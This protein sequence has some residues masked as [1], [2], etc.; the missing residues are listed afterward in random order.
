MADELQNLAADL[1]RV[2]AEIPQT[3]GL[4]DDNGSL[5]AIALQRTPGA[6]NGI[7]GRQQAPS[8]AVP[9]PF[10]LRPDDLNPV[11]SDP[12]QTVPPPQAVSP[13]ISAPDPQ[14]IASSDL[15]PEDL[16]G[17]T[18]DLLDDQ[19]VPIDIR[20]DDLLV[21]TSPSQAPVDFLNVQPQTPQDQE[22]VSKLNTRIATSYSEILA[23]ETP[24]FAELSRTQQTDLLNR[25]RSQV[26]LEA[27]LDIGAEQT[28][29]EFVSEDLLGDGGIT[30]RLPFIGA[31][32]DGVYF[33]QAYSAAKAI[34]S[35]SA[36]LADWE[37]LADFQE[38]IVSQ[39]RGKTIPAQAAS[40]MSESIPFM[41]EF[42]AS[43]GL[44]SLVKGGARTLTKEGA[45]E[46]AKKSL[47]EILLVGAR[48]TVTSAGETLIRLPV[49]SHRVAADAIR[50]MI[51]NFILQPGDENDI[52][53]IVDSPGDELM[54]AL[55]N[56]TLDTSIEIFSEQSGQVLG[57]LGL[58]AGKVPGARMTL[59][60]FNDFKATVVAG[61]M[62][63]TGFDLRRATEFLARAGYHGVIAEMGEERVG[64]L[65][66]AAV[67]L[68]PLQFPSGEQ[69]AAE[70]LAFAGIGA[71]GTASASLFQEAFPKTRD[72]GDRDVEIE[73]AEK[74][75]K[76][77]Q[78]TAPTQPSA[79]TPQTPQ[80]GGSSGEVGRDESPLDREVDPTGAR[81]VLQQGPEGR[82]RVFDTKTQKVQ[83]RFGENVPP[84]TAQTIVDELNEIEQ[85]GSIQPAPQTPPDPDEGLNEITPEIASDLVEIKANPELV[86]ESLIL[87][88]FEH[89]KGERFDYFLH[90]SKQWRYRVQARNIRREIKNPR[91]GGWKLVPQ[92]NVPITVKDF[93]DRLRLRFAEIQQPG[94]QSKQVE[95]RPAAESDQEVKEL[96]VQINGLEARLRIGQN[97]FGQPLKPAGRKQIDQLL[98]SARKRLLALREPP[99]A[100]EATKVTPEPVK[101][102][103]APETAPAAKP[104]QEDQLLD[105]LADR[106]LPEPSGTAAADFEERAEQLEKEGKSD[107]EIKEI[108]DREFPPAR[109]ASDIVEDLEKRG[110]PTGYIALMTRPQS[111]LANPQVHEIARSR[112]PEVPETLTVFGAV[113]LNERGIWDDLIESAL[114]GGVIPTA[115]DQPAAPTNLTNPATPIP[116]SIRATVYRATGSKVSPLAEGVPENVFGVGTYYAF[117]KAD[118][119]LFGPDVNQV[120]VDL[121]NPYWITNHDDYTNMLGRAFP[122]T[123]EEYQGIAKLARAFMAKHGHDGVVVA[124]PKQSDIDF[125][126]KNAKRLRT[127]FVV[128]Q[129]FKIEEARQQQ[130]PEIPVSGTPPKTSSET[131]S[132]IAEKVASANPAK[133]AKIRADA[134]KMDKSIDEKMNPAIATQ[135]VTRRRS[136]I[137]E[138][139][140]ADG[141]RLIKIQAQ[142]RAIADRLDAG[143][144]P[145]ELATVSGRAMLERLNFVRDSANL[146]FLDLKDMNNLVKFSKTGKG[147]RDSKV[148]KARDLVSKLRD[149][150]QVDDIRNTFGVWVTTS[151]ESAAVN[152]LLK[153]LKDNDNR[154]KVFFQL[155]DNIR[156]GLRFIRAYES[157]NDPAGSRGLIDKF[158]VKMK[159]QLDALETK[160]VGERTDEQKELEKAERDLIGVQIPGFFPTPEPVINTLL[161]KAEIEADHRVLEPS[162]GKGDIAEKLREIV[163]ADNLAINELSLTLRDILRKKGFEG[164]EGD[165]FDRKVEEKYDRIVMNPPFEKGADIDHVSRAFDM[166]KPGGRLVSIMGEGV[167]SR[168][169]KKEKAFREFLELH[170][171]EIEKLPEGAF[172]SSF[173]ST[174]VATRVVTIDKESQGDLDKIDQEVNEITDKVVQL[175]SRR[176]IIADSPPSPAKDENLKRLDEQ[177]EAERGKV[178]GKIDEEK[179]VRDQLE[180]AVAAPPSITSTAT[181]S[182]DKSATDI[183]NENADQ[184]ARERTESMVQQIGDT[185]DNGNETE[186]PPQTQAETVPQDAQDVER[187]KEANRQ[188]DHLDGG[189]DERRAVRFQL[190]DDQRQELDKQA[191]APLPD[192]LQ[193]LL[194][195]KQI[196][197]DTAARLL[198]SPPAL[199][200]VTYN[201]DFFKPKRVK[202]LTPLPLGV[203]TEA[204]A[205]VDRQK[206][207]AFS[208]HPF[209]N[210]LLPKWVELRRKI[211]A[212]YHAG[213]TEVPV[214]GV[215]NASFWAE[216]GAESKMKTLAN[217]A[218]KIKTTG[219]FKGT[220]PFTAKKQSLPLGR[221][222]SGSMTDKIKSMQPGMAR[223][224]TR[225]AINKIMITPTEAVVTDNRVMWKME[226]DFTD[227]LGGKPAA[228]YTLDKKGKPTFD[229]EQEGKTLDNGSR[230]F[231]PE[232]EDQ[233]HFPAWKDVMPDHVDPVTI[234]IESTYDA[235]R[236]SKVMVHEEAK[237]VIIVLNPPTESKPQ[238]ERSLG[239]VT[240]NPELGQSEINV[241][242]DAVVI[243]AINPDFMMQALKMH[244]KNGS[245]TVEFSMRDHDR[246]VRMDGINATTIVMPVQ[247]GSGAFDAARRAAAPGLY[248]SDVE[249]TLS[250]FRSDY[251]TT[252]AV[253]TGLRTA[254]RHTETGEIWFAIEGSVSY[255]FGV[256]PDKYVKGKDENQRADLAIESGFVDPSGP[257][258]VW[259]DR[260]EVIHRIARHKELD[261]LMHDSG[262]A[263]AQFNPD[264]VKHREALATAID[265]Y[266]N[267]QGMLNVSGAGSVGKSKMV[268]ERQKMVDAAKK[269]SKAL[270][271]LSE[272][273]DQDFILGRSGSKSIKRIT[274]AKQLRYKLAQREINKIDPDGS[275]VDPDISSHPVQE[276]TAEELEHMRNNPDKPTFGMGAMANIPDT[277]GWT[278]KIYDN[279]ARRM[280]NPP[281]GTVRERLFKYIGRGIYGYQWGMTRKQFEEFERIKGARNFADAVASDIKAI[282]RQD[283]EERIKTREKARGP[284]SFVRREVILKRWRRELEDALRGDASITTLSKRQLEIRELY[285]APTRYVTAQILSNEW[286][287]PYLRAFGLK[288]IEQVIAIRS[289]GKGE[290]LRRLYEAKPGDLMYPLKSTLREVNIGFRI[291]GGQF[292]LRRGDE[293]FYY[294]F[295]TT[296]P[297]NPQ[298]FAFTNEDD[299]ETERLRI[300][301]LKIGELGT[302]VFD[303]V[304]I[305]DPFS[306]DELEAKGLIKPI[307]DVEILMTRSLVD[308]LENLQT[309]KTFAYLNDTVGIESAE[310]VEGYIDLPN[311]PAL[312]PLAGRAVPEPIWQAL[313]Q[314]ETV[315]TG[316]LFRVWHTYNFA[317]KKSKVL[318]SLPTWMRNLRSVV[319]FQFLDNMNPITDAKWLYQA[320]KEFQNHGPNWE[321]LVKRNEI[322]RGWTGAELKDFQTLVTDNIADWPTSANE[323]ID[324]HPKLIQAVKKWGAKAKRVEDLM[325]NLYEMPDQ[326]VKLASYLKKTQKTG[327]TEDE[328]VR[329]LWMYHNYDRAGRFAVR[330]RRSPI[331]PLFIMFDEQMLKIYMRAFRDKPGR[332]LALATA[333]ALITLATRMLLGVSD[334]EMEILNQDVRRQGAWVN[335]YMQPIIPIRDDTG[336]IQFIDLRYEFPMVDLFKLE[337]GAGG[338]ALPYLLTQ[339]WIQMIKEAGFNQI[340]YTG[341]AI[342]F[343]GDAFMTKIGKFAQHA[344]L[345][346]APIPSFV[347]KRGGGGVQRIFNAALGNGREG[348]TRVLLREVFGIRVQQPW[349]RRE[350]AFKLC[351]QLYGQDAADHLLTTLG[352]FDEIYAEEFDRRINVSD[353]ARAHRRDRKRELEIAIARGGEI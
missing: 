76:K 133:A 122:T 9:T 71:G 46:I 251:T 275:I 181:P 22:R 30:R 45:E 220:T 297:K 19:N 177:I 280:L 54:A 146:A 128:S 261:E 137:I 102:V 74:G 124:V 166:L 121:L 73:A 183:E 156:D 174:G 117:T 5:Q 151:E 240:Y 268:I 253:D 317:F 233:I 217:K 219:V 77:T 95:A 103:V 223:E 140:R 107:D 300:I 229:S 323:W 96:E 324:G 118:A 175:R 274:A 143:T 17:F 257:Q 188:T 291:R 86:K 341:Q 230:S 72:L 82:I 6:N 304:V 311:H 246:P 99:K 37:I 31:V 147:A 187:I 201:L 152:T 134:D 320:I 168:Q 106:D 313:N 3:P 193:K 94:I 334:D 221:E 155:G 43:G 61:F 339:P 345:T 33:Y 64:E 328:A 189:V 207:I 267:Y 108:L 344:V 351:K 144:L 62:Q 109:S 347:V 35:G 197:F 195:Q 123:V 225:Y 245:E 266:D 299:A 335:K 278:A 91:T 203:P 284:I 38:D 49:F 11:L 120:E 321:V 89:T 184:A 141:E 97:I 296:D 301:D 196:P 307:R 101:P 138:G 110:V 67:G 277:R 248:A 239:F 126:G 333:P 205:E 34:E 212:A 234:D 287:W 105:D 84:E 252:D 191:A 186:A 41:V 312:G 139:M 20:P 51:P 26:G 235:L 44:V 163:G 88:G 53:F 176:D 244:W 47:S 1:A 112:L 55:K 14:D 199:K 327:M 125:Q 80:D 173:R 214:T 170:D 56:A 129:L 227:L 215:P 314:I 295:D 204:E 179:R 281:A 194:D 211:Q 232:G 343:E 28:V 249:A 308:S 309:L 352:L 58:A 342:W 208:Q 236:K 293:D 113:S 171:A 131:S 18:G 116:G 288:N 66:R 13:A 302:S 119:E 340:Q 279:I 306:V 75:V 50:R 330:L 42:L 200:D 81:Y 130:K 8:Q 272:L 269:L 259:V 24:G 100:V 132:K 349:I 190:P 32:A 136:G 10:D 209:R 290:Y 226:A 325:S 303:K 36:T 48:A 273:A 182:V 4:G 60:K 258:N 218:A 158:A 353:L 79:I 78:E 57:V 337:T 59:R 104:D 198:R 332:L 169:G 326:V 90:P 92:G 260:Q 69:L 154:G 27:T 346:A 242:L 256:I 165:F 12:V 111:S 178:A 329:S 241:E 162:A 213:L 331:G 285:A 29:G 148:V 228:L 68:A 237:G 39:A 185:D 294:V 318:W 247:A 164:V 263:A 98:Q 319:V 336:A 265:A 87:R 15:R 23:R 65:L 298:S 310:D 2:Q 276:F 85:P 338:V 286:M 157:L 254:F 264:D 206:H 172:K 63:K 83:T 135:N 271:R 222:H 161:D 7:N 202:N 216:P 255:D 16:T 160:P 159:E 348:I 270:P 180:N 316:M 25:A 224:S 243:G 322:N 289:M 145:I 305:L 149:G 192:D 93:A 231:G 153:H 115:P 40:I 282:A 292:M 52:A 283:I 114:G 142:M 250:K 150:A 262:L 21:S 127:I 210:R 350:D 315:R 167:F 70:A 238:T